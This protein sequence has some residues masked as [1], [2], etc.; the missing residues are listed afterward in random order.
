MTEA[1]TPRYG[2]LAYTSFGQPHSTSDAVE[3]HPTQ[4]MQGFR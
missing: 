3:L 4:R 2:R 1:M